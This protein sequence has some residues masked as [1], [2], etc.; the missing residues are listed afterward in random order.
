MLIDFQKAFNSVS[1]QVLYKVLEFFGYDEQFTSLVQL[2]NNDIETYLIHCGYYLN[3][4]VFKGD[5]NKALPFY[6]S[7]RN[8]YSVDR[9]QPK[10]H[11]NQCGTNTNKTLIIHG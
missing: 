9:I 2:F 10:Y 7:C 6:F 5:V 11:R 8:T 1:R 3:Q 4:L